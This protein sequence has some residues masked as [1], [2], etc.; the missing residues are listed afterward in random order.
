MKHSA[1]RIIDIT[2]AVGLVRY[3]VNKNMPET[4]SMRARTITKKLLGFKWMISKKSCQE[5]F[6]LLSF[7]YPKSKNITPTTSRNINGAYILK[8]NNAGNMLSILGL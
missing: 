2:R 8:I 5:F 4:I 3:P 1:K 6:S 7:R